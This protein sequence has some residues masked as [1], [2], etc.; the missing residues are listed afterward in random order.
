MSKRT[1]SM[2]RQFEDVVRQMQGW[3]VGFDQLFGGIAQVMHNAT[4]YP[5]YNVVRHDDHYVIEIALAGLDPKEV[6]VEMENDVL[7]VKREIGAT[8]VNKEQPNYVHKGIANRN[9][10]LT[11]QI[12]NDH[13]VESASVHNGLLS[14]VIQK[15][16]SEP[17]RTSIPVMYN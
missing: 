6:V 13:R 8:D 7:C 17:T 12:A 9:F 16:K 15:V 1:E 5:P 14:I 10:S 11:F 2:S 3:A 4:G